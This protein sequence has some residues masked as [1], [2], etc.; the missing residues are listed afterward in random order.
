MSRLH[1][2]RA[3]LYRR[4]STTDQRVYGNSLGAQ[5]DAL[6]AFCN[7][8]GIEIIQEFE[9]DFSAKTFEKR[10]VFQELLDYAKSHS[11]EIDLLL[12]TRIDRFSRNSIATHSMIHQLES[13]GIEVN[14]TENWMN[15]D[16]PYQ[17]MTRVIQVAQPESENLIKAHRTKTGMRQAL[18][19]GRYI[20][21]QPIGY[22]P[23]MD[24][25]GK[26][27]MKPDPIK[28]PLAQ[29]LF[30]LYASGR[31]SQNQLLQER[32]FKPLKLSK[33]SLSRLLRNT[34]YTGRVVVP[35]FNGEEETIVQG[36]HEPLIS[37]A[38]FRKVQSILNIKQR[39][40]AKANKLNPELPLRGHL[41]CPSCGRNLTG[42]GSRGK[43]GKRHFYYHCEKRYGCNYRGR[44]NE[45]HEAFE[46]LVKGIQPTTGIVA[47]FEAVLRD[48]F[49]SKHNSIEQNL[50]GAETL[51]KTLENKREMLLE[52]LLEG[53]VSNG[54]YKSGSARLDNQIDETKSEIDQLKQTD[55]GIED[56]IPFG[57]SLI[58][59]L[60]GVFKSASIETKHQLLSSILA[61]KLE[62]KDGKYRTPVFKEGFDLIFQS[63]NQLQ[64]E[65]QKTGDRIAAISRLVPG[66]GLEPARPFGS[67]DFKSVVS[68][69]ST[70]QA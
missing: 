64:S 63:V 33:S 2:K 15:W 43:S 66:A 70:I 22:Q 39:T 36:L 68:T 27:L 45:H 40:A 51:L 59:N 19:E 13:W 6:R 37:L 29:E 52:K 25:V 46:D 18:K 42:S 50:Q 58:S 67:T 41:K 49:N 61:E 56:F 53:V 21:R 34:L 4:V 7:S 24:E 5:R 32:R 35:Q 9:E 11:A 12:A 10:G 20:G 16:D 44:R 65:N 26:A 54:H 47:L 38:T 30:M 31:F 14:F 60:N 28:A 69:N 3:I 1:G 17:H 62:L 55:S 23:G 57:I 8:N 48:V